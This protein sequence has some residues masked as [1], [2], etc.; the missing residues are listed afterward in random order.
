MTAD[1]ELTAAWRSLVRAETEMFRARTQF[2]G[3]LR[4]RADLSVLA[5]ALEVPHERGTAL[6]CISCLRLDERQQLFPELMRS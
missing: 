2:L 6:R 1:D 5:R 4:D 3:L